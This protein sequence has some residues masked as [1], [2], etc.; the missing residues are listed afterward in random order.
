MDPPLC[1]CRHEALSCG[2]K[3]GPGAPA[4]R[5]QVTLHEAAQL[6]A[7]AQGF[8]GWGPSAAYPCSG[9]RAAK[10]AFLARHLLD[11]LNPAVALRMGD[12][13]MVCF[14]LTQGALTLALLAAPRWW[15]VCLPGGASKVKEL[16]WLH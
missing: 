6:R 9:P 4:Q 16:M 11:A 14:M 5:G 12:L 10:A 15:V 7:L 2:S 8:P 1:P 3:D 13:A